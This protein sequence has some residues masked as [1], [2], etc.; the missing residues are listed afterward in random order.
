MVGTRDATESVERV[1]RIL[2]GIRGH[3]LS[4][5]R[6][7]GVVVEVAE[8]LAD[9]ARED[10]SVLETRRRTMLARLVGDER[11]KAL[12]VA[13]ADQ[14]HRP[15]SNARM[16]AQLEYLVGRLGLPSYLPTIARVAFERALSSRL[17]SDRVFRDAIELGV[18]AETR[19]L[20][21]DASRR[22]VDSLVKARAKEDVRVTLNVL[23]EEVLGEREAEARLTQYVNLLAS[24]RVEAVSV[25]ISS[26]ASQRSALA[27]EWTVNEIVPRLVRIYDA[28]VARPRPA[29]VTLGHGGVRRRRAHVRRV[30]SRARE[31]G[32]RIA[33]RGHRDPGVSPGCPWARA[34]AR[35]VREGAGR[36]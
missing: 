1:Q 10:E 14:L 30:P 17:L 26:I 15:R 3:P 18:R 36:T 28:A 24:P 12:T 13:L 31:A 16:R 5:E 34:S 19:G 27:H 35:C 22:A 20:V 9:A 11:G 2:R 8:G 4:D 29:R 33:R 21:H 6:R 32:L 25:K 23:G 7:A